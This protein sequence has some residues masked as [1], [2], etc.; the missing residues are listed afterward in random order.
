[1]TDGLQPFSCGD[2]QKLGET[3]GRISSTIRPKTDSESRM[4]RGRMKLWLRETLMLMVDHP[5][6]VQ[7]MEGNTEAN[8]LQLRIQVHPDDT[9]KIIGK[10][11]R[12]ARALRAVILAMGHTQQHFFTIDMVD[13]DRK[14][15]ERIAAL[16]AEN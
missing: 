13:G 2:R 15:Q 16:K 9:G 14:T 12:N 5:G 10:M 6:S 7:I 4:L 11:G 3:L 8:S 1:M